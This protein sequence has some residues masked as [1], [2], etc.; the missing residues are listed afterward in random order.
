MDWARDGHDWPHHAHSRFVRSGG[1]RWHVQCWPA[2]RPG[3]PELLLLHGTG[4]STHSWRTLIPLL[5]TQAGVTAVDLPG[6]GFSDAAPPGGATLPG[7][8]AGVAALLRELG[9]QP[10]LII[11]HSAGAAIAVQMAL[12]QPPGLRSLVS[13]NGAL[14]PLHGLAG[15]VFSPLAKL[16]AGSP[17]V[18]QFFAR[19]AADPPRL[20]RLVDSTGSRIDEAGIALYGK[21]VAD[22]AHVAGA[23]A[24]MAHWDLQ[25]LA[26]RLPRLQTPLHLIAADGDRTLPAGH[27][28][29]VAALLPQAQLTLLRGLGHLA[30][31]EDP[32]R[33]W[34]VLQPLLAEADGAATALPDESGPA[35]IE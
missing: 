29:R 15:R 5:A 18:P 4:A 11:G 34:Q 17:L 32:Q 1:R 20:R 3:A 23:L 2:P 19:R 14:L 22:P 12:A 35:V 9:V 8:A 16:L 7:M 28:Q 25:A 6:H 27:S 24:M 33:V 30:H 26:E 10:A 13:L 31:E 21:L